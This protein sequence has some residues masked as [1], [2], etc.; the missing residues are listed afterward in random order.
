MKRSYIEKDGEKIECWYGERIVW[1][2]RPENFDYFKVYYY[3][4]N[5]KH[6]VQVS[7]F[8]I[9]LDNKWHSSTHM[10]RPD[11]VWRHWDREEEYD[12]EYMKVVLMDAERQAMCI[13]YLPSQETNKQYLEHMGGLIAEMEK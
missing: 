1:Q 8:Q 7:E 10:W 12:D 11:G 2:K 4:E 3:S 13:P 6:I 9:R 5:P